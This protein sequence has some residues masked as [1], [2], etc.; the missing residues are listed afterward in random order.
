MNL[1]TSTINIISDGV[2]HVDGGEV[3]GQIPKIKWEKFIKPDRRNRVKLALNSLVIK[4]PQSNILIDT[5][6]GS[7]RTDLLKEQYGLNGNKLLRGIRSLGLTARDIDIIILTSLQFDHAGGATK[8]DR[9]GVAVPSFP[10]AKYIVQK[11]A[12]D[13]ANNPGQRFEGNYFQ[14]D[15]MPLYEK[16]QLQIIDGNSMI[17]PGVSVEVNDGPAAG[18]QIVLIQK[19]SEKIAYVGDLIPTP[20]HLD[21]SYISAKDEKPNDTLEQKLKILETS[22][23]NGWLLIFGHSLEYKSGYISGQNGTMRFEPIELS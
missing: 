2:F 4:T 18:H 20:Y 17:I 23:G 9:T 12:W 8:L 22:L 14:D 21:P 3:F 16:D 19:G 6:A 5:G 11:S 13:K 7:K 1:G 15:F 10:K